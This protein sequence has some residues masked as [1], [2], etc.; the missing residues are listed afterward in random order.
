[1]VWGNSHV[2]VLIVGSISYIAIRNILR[3]ANILYR[4]MIRTLSD[5]P[6]LTT[7]IHGLDL[8]DV[9]VLRIY[10]D[11]D[12]SYLLSSGT[13]LRSIYVSSIGAIGRAI[14]RNVGTVTRTAISSIGF[15]SC[16]KIVRSSLGIYLNDYYNYVSTTITVVTPTIISPSRRDGGRWGGGPPTAVSTGR[17]IVVSAISDDNNSVYWTVVSVRGVVSFFI[18]LRRSNRVMVCCFVPFGVY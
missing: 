13:N 2:Y 6:N 14:V 9:Y 10:C 12:V 5:F 1:M 7:A 18:C 16:Y 4:V 8:W 17:T 15:T 3:Y 11:V